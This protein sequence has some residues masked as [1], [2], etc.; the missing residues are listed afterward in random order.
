M[1]N[2]RTSDGIMEADWEVIQ[3]LAADIANVVMAQ[4]Y[5]TARVTTEKLLSQISRLEEKYG[6]LPS[7]LA[8]R[9][10]CIDDEK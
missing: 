4:N 6:R 1:S 5:G 2:T 7:L 10:D 9:A 8:T 3:V